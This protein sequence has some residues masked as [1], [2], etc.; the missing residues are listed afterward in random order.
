MCLNWDLN[1]QMDLQLYISVN[2]SKPP[3]SLRN[4]LATIWWFA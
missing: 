3:N 2:W 1:K 4:M